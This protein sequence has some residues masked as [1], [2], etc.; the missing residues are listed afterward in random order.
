MLLAGAVLV[1]FRYTQM[2]TRMPEEDILRQI[3]EGFENR[4][5]FPQVVRAIHGTHIPVSKPND[6]PSNYYNRKGFYSIIMQAVVDN[7][8]LF[9]DSY[10]GWP[11]KVHDSRVLINSTF[12]KKAVLNKLLPNWIRKLCGVEISLVILGDPAYP[13]LPSLMKP[14]LDNQHSS[15]KEKHFNYRHSRAR[16]PVENAFG[17][18][19]GR[20][21]CLMKR[22]DIAISN[23]PNVVA[24][25]VVLQNNFEMHG[26]KC[27]PKWID[28]VCDGNIE[29]SSSII[30][31]TFHG[32]RVHKGVFM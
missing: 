5:G 4:W 18:W 6:S 16:M 24:A 13:L 26:E 20:W 17:R 21:R 19:K 11:G 14:Y 28:I 9:L 29:V 27:Q 8:G 32:K 12:Y 3:I 2:I 15:P 22:M 30:I 1:Y 25:C 31:V 23:V 10:I 7:N